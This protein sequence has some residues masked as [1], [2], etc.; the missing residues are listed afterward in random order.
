MAMTK[1]SKLRA[2]VPQELFRRWRRQ[3][4]IEPPRSTVRSMES[5]QTVCNSTRIFEKQ[6]DE[7][8]KRQK[9]SKRILPIHY[10]TLFYQKSKR[11]KTRKTIFYIFEKTTQHIWG[12]IGRA[13]TIGRRRRTNEKL[14]WFHSKEP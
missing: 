13:T 5:S 10:T 3:T 14:Y 2:C 9:N 7:R 8:R 11:E 4:H 1:E 12:L 6:E